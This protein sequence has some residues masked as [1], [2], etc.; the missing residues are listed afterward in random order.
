MVSHINGQ[1]ANRLVPSSLRSRAFTLVELLV[2][3]AIIGILVALLLPAIQAAREAAR[4]IQCK[5]NLKNIGLACLNHE[6]TQK[7]FPTGGETWGVSIENYLNPPPDVGPGG[8]LLSVDQIGLGWGFQLLPYLEEGAVH[9]LTGTD[10]VR[11]KVIPIYVCPSRRG[12]TRAPNGWVLTDYAGVNPTTRVWVTDAN[13]VDINPA[14]L[15]Y[16][17]VLNCFYKPS[18]GNPS[19]KNNGSASNPYTG[20]SEGP[21]AQDTGAYDGVIVRS[22][23]HW[24]SYDPFSG[25]LGKYASN[26]APSPTKVSKITDGTSK[27]MMIGEKY[28]RSDMYNGFGAQGTTP[29]DDTGWGDGWD[30][31][32][33]RTTA[34]P[35][36]NDGQSNA[37]YTGDF[38]EA[39][40]GHGVWEV[41]VMGSA[42]TGGFNAVFADG[43]VRT[44]NYD[45][46]VY[47][48]NA[49][50]TRNGTSA[51]S[52]GASSPEVAD[53]SSGG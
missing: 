25:Q 2:V 24:T 36:L 38:G 8:K 10:D 47:V 1:T 4:K 19:G 16:G 6:S 50:G 12:V 33:M 3:I 41:L 45:I 7:V 31:D 49:L 15:N 44:I 35:P 51:G 48:F 40:G 18:S 22:P 29:S 27:T 43:G 52:N 23:W 30:P 11:G 5:D 42:H 26:G 32:V 17:Q 53:T 9:S 13:P 34:I 21:A 28:I 14:N 20:Q 37:S 46:D 39:P